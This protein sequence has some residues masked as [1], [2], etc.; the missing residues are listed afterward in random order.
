MLMELIYWREN[1][2]FVN[3]SVGDLDNNGKIDYV[4]WIVP[5]LSNQTFDIILITKANK[6]KHGK[7]KAL[8]TKI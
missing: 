3:F 2:S 7:N 8:T 1:E 6:K 4:E 5:H